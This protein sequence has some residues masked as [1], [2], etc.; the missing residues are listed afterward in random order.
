MS[1]VSRSEFVWVYQ[2]PFSL[3]VSQRLYRLFIYEITPNSLSSHPLGSDSWHDVGRLFLFTLSVLFRAITT[4]ECIC[5]FY[6]SIKMK[7]YMMYLAAAEPNKIKAYCLVLFSSMTP[8]GMRGAFW[9]GF[10]LFIPRS[11]ERRDVN[12]SCI[13]FRYWLN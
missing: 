10:F 8:P 13:L 11:Q 3:L 4:T 2:T 5:S 6:F 1:A 12:N 7:L 9:L